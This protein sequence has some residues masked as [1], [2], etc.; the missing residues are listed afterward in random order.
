MKLSP[1]AQLFVR[2]AVAEAAS[3]TL[4]L[5]ARR[6]GGDPWSGELSPEAAQL[7]K[8]ALDDHRNLL[9]ARLEMPLTDDEAADL[10][11]DLGFIDAVRSDLVAWLKPV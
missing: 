8:A 9:R 6:L 4:R 1:K 7:A 11:N 3:Q 5:A 2:K 10:S